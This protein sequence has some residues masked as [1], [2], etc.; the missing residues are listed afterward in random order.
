MEDARDR[1]MA[2]RLPETK[3]KILDWLP[4]PDRRDLF[5]EGLE[6]IG[7]SLV[8]LVEHAGGDVDTR[9]LL[10]K[11]GLFGAAVL[12]D[13]PGGLSE[14]SAQLLRVLEELLLKRG[15]DR[16]GLLRLELLRGRYRLGFDLRRA[17]PIGIGEQ[18]HEPVVRRS[19][20][21]RVEGRLE[22]G[23]EGVVIGLW[24]RVVAMVVALG[25]A[26]GEPE[27]RTGHNRE[28]VG[29]DPVAALGIP[30]A[31]RP[32]GRH[33]QEA[34]GR[35]PLDRLRR[36]LGM[37]G[38]DELVAGELLDEEAIQRQVGVEGAHDPVA[39]LPGVGPGRIVLRGAGGVGVA[40]RIEPMA[41]PPL[42]IVG[43]GEE[44]IDEVLVG[45]RIGVGDEGIDLL[46]SGRKTEEIKRRPAD[47]RR[48]VGRRREGEA[49]SL[50][51][52]K[53][54]G[55]DRL[56][57]EIGV[58][59]G[60]ER[61]ADKGAE[62]PPLPL[63]RRD[64][65]AGGNRLRLGTGC[66]GPGGD[67][68]FENRQFFRRHLER[69]GGHLGGA[70][71]RHQQARPG[72]PPGDRRP[73]VAAALHRAHLPQIEIPLEGIAGPVAVEAVGPEDRAD[74]AFEGKGGVFGRGLQGHSQPA[75]G[76]EGEGPDRKW[77]A[78]RMHRNW[79]LV[80][81]KNAP[82]GSGTV[83]QYPS[84]GGRGETRFVGGDLPQRLPPW[85]N[86]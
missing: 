77:T 81:R 33:P 57:D 7:G 40:C 20:R 71:P 2:G 26:D 61:G 9:P 43:R 34:G 76:E 16:R 45:R 3:E 85:Q 30:S 14:L 8:V 44:P 12:L 64:A 35:Q 70:D 31:G 82:E 32:V 63:L 79:A 52:G 39:V 50:E 29:H 80:G 53:E 27:E 10:E 72:I 49:S 28:R 37:G 78:S 23:A 47:E 51:A 46:G 42:A 84:I 25:T 41:G 54:E 55:V 86:R 60:R 62:R 5:S 38:R 83:H 59:H 74:V 36:E 69:R 18:R 15:G 21:R 6:L 58:G 73:G 13:S 1:E 66:R 56:R 48:P 24:D 17:G 4:R 65:E 11:L 19:P 22:E 67:P 75:E 68:A